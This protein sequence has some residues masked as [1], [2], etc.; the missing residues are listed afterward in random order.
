MGEDYE[1]K[2]GEKGREEETKRKSGRGES[3]RREEG[4]EK[5]VRR[6]KGRMR[7]GGGRGKTDDGGRRGR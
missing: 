4:N 6:E 1:T 7:G 5:A 3:W 2:A